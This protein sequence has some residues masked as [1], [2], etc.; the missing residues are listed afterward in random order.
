METTARPYD[1]IGDRI[2]PEPRSPLGDRVEQEPRTQTASI[3]APIA[4]KFRERRPPTYM[5]RSDN[6][7]TIFQVVNT[8]AATIHTSIP[9]PALAPTASKFRDIQPSTY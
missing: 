7:G 5:R 3:L 4:S 9:G 1:L 6:T 2:G 8:S